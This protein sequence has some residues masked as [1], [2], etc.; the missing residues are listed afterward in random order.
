VKFLI[1]PRINADKRK[2]D[3]LLSAFIRV[4]PR[5]ILFSLALSSCGYHVAG[6]ADLVPKSVH[7]IAIPAFSNITTR[8]KL[9]DH[10]PEAITREFIART[11]YQIITDTSQADAV[12]RGAIVNYVAYPTTI[13]QQTGRASGLQV[14]VT[15]QVSLTERATGKVI[16]TRPSFEVHQRY[17]LSI[18]AGAYFDESDAAL[19]RLSRDVARDLVSAILENF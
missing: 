16:F 8:Y 7:T 11:R 2:S 4:H 18:K 12:L 17:E 9:T 15:L 1:R 19:D 14:N 5:L 13:D 6:K 3:S 10:L